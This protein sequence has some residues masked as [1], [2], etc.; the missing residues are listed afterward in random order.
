MGKGNIIG[1]YAVIGE[2]GEQRG[3]HPDDFKGLVVIGD[4]NRISEHV[5][6][7]RP[8]ES[9]KSTK[10]GNDNFIMAHSHIGHDAVIGDNN[11]L[12]TGTIVGGYVTITNDTRIK[13]GVTI[14]NRVFVSCGCVIGM[15]SVV[16]KDVEPFTTVY[17]NPAKEK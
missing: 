10:I 15:G 13:L 17:G 16:I 2:A 3:K 12:C 1:A 5:T 14:R 6:I 7:Q 8:Y 9:D 4:N 11:E